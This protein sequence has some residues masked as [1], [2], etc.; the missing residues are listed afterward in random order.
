[1]PLMWR[2][3]GCGEIVV[4]G[5]FVMDGE[6]LA[7]GLKQEVERLR[8]VVDTIGAQLTRDSKRDFPRFVLDNIANILKEKKE[9][10]DAPKS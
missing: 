10:S 5:E 7:G 6:R 1:M 4:T 9:G 3:S 2:E 8:G